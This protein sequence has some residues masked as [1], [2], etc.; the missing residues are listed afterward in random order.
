MKCKTLEIRWHDKTYARTLALAHTPARR[1]APPP[2]SPHS[3]QLDSPRAHAPTDTLAPRRPIFSADFHPLAPAPA[4]APSKP[5]ARTNAAAHDLGDA[6]RTDRN[7][8]WRLAT[9]GADNNVRVSPVLLARVG[10]SS[11]RSRT[12]VGAIS[13]TRRHRPRRSGSSTHAPSRSA[14][15]SPSPPPPPRPPRRRRRRNHSPRNRKQRPTPTPTRASSTSRPS[16]STRASSTASGGPPKVRARA[17]ISPAQSSRR[18]RGSFGTPGKSCSLTRRSHAF[19]GD[20]LASAGD[21][22]NILL[23]VPA[24]PASTLPA[25]AGAGAAPMNKAQT[26][27][28]T[29]EDRAYEKESWR[30]R[31]MIRC[32]PL[33]P[34]ASRL[35]G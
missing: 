3:P 24:D 1:L 30:V 13:L 34:F 25:G 33:G 22:G 15:R 31:A 10:A 23:W 4:S 20:M 26:F 19:A 2:H 9:C 28:E 17:V 6:D 14:P 11:A 7:K 29:D 27:G 5:S 18:L 32:A 35:S 16:A 8:R 12:F 21:D